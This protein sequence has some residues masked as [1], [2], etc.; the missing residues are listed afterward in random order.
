MFWG[1][2]KE[3][4][5]LGAPD[6]RV[7]SPELTGFCPCAIRANVAA[8]AGAPKPAVTRVSSPLGA[9]SAA[10]A[11]GGASSGP[12]RL[13]SR[14]RRLLSWLKPQMPRWLPGRAR[15]SLRRHIRT[16][17]ASRGGLG[18]VPAYPADLS[19]SPLS[20]FESIPSW[21]SQSRAPL[22]GLDVKVRE[23]PWPLG[24]KAGACRFQHSGGGFQPCQ[25]PA[26]DS[27]R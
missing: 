25:P 11:G 12:W 15:L 8:E 14:K 4:R 3:R 17:G 5:G 16:G 7:L 20:L 6:S 2:A 10:V 9:T 22:R 27:E 23:T 19:T 1:R 21:K 13:R 18:P 24:A 26:A